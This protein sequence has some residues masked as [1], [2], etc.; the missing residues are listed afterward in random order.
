VANCPDPGLKALTIRLIFRGLKHTAGK[1][2]ILSELDGRHP[3]GAEAHPLFRC[4]CG[5]TEEVEKKLA[6]S[7]KSG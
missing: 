2:L 1:G 5:T 3:S 6:D 7:G 4:V